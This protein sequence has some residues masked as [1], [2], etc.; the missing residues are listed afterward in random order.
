MSYTALA[1]LAVQATGTSAAA[2]VVHLLWANVIGGAPSAQE[3]QPYVDLL[4]GGMSIGQ[5]TVLA[6]DTAL[7]AAN[8]DL[9]GLAKTGVEFIDPA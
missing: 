8:I 9:I 2:D 4:N 1:N 6:A 5:L 7:N 3:A